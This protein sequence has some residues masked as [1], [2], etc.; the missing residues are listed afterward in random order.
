MD[1][2]WAEERDTGPGHHGQV[3]PLGEMLEEAWEG[4]AAR[5]A[6]CTDGDVVATLE[7]RC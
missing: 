1:G 6:N 2:W 7:V 5:L 4:Y 3:D